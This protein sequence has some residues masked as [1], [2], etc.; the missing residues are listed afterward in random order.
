[1]DVISIGELP[2]GRAEILQIK[3]SA[4]AFGRQALR[5]SSILIFTRAI[6]AP[7]TD[8]HV[9]IGPSFAGQPGNS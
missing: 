7:S 1:M 6:G 5:N 4:S 2:I 3:G 9:C 8:A